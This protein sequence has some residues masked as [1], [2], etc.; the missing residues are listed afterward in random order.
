MTNN[1]KLMT[2][3]K[4]NNNCIETSSVVFNGIDSEYNLLTQE[5][6]EIIQ[7]YDR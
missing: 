1:L 7:E 3:I 6:D 2:T 4:S 5:E